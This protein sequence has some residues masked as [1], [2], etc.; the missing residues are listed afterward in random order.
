MRAMQAPLIRRAVAE[1]LWT[2]TRL[3]ICQS[4]SPSLSVELNVWELSSNS[5]VSDTILK[6][7]ND[8]SSDVGGVAP[9]GC[10]R[11]DEAG[12]TA[13]QAD[14]EGGGGDSPSLLPAA[15]G[16]VNEGECRPSNK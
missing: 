8:S 16:L 12:Q 4:S 2:A 1:P 14:R 9:A 3:V 15:V 6:R 10:V 5:S 13:G 7:L 11:P